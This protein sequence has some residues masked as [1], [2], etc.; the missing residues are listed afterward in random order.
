MIYLSEKGVKGSVT[1]VNVGVKAQQVS[2]G[3]CMLEKVQ[4]RRVYGV[5]G[6]LESWVTI[7]SNPPPYKGWMLV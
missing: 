4:V 6:T 3:V 2:K 5:R 1:C 7:R